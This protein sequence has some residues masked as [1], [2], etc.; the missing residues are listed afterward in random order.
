M[1]V[2]NVE[3]GTEEWLKLRCGIATGSE[4]NKLV[5]ATGKASSQVK[6][7]AM[8]LAAE[9]YAG[10]PVDPFQGNSAT[11]RGHLLEPDAREFYAFTISEPVTEV[12]FVTNDEETVGCSPDSLVGEKGL[13]EIKCPLA[14]KFLDCLKYTKEGQCPPDYFLQVQGQLY[15][16]GREW[17]DLFVY[18]PQLPSRPVRVFPDAMYQ[19]IIGNQLE[20]LAQLKAEAVQM[21]IDEREAA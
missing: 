16:T 20:V 21:L 14:P 1:R 13:L 8:L 11:E 10:G 7:Y 5:T 2:H 19:D 3:Q 4:F 6:A 17:C 9:D 15:V 18:H 12:G